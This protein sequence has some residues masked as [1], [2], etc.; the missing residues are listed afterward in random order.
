MR[1]ARAGSASARAAASPREDDAAISQRGLP[2]D[3]RVRVAEHAA[4]ARSGEEP[5]SSPMFMPPVKATRRS[6][7]RILR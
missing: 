5:Y 6:T 3:A 7:T 2:L 4:P 1:R